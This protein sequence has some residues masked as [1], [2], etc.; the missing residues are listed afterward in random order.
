M[1]LWLLYWIFLKATLS[2]FSGMAALPI[3]R[4]ELVVQRQLLTDRDLNKAIVIGRTTPGPK[5]L[6]VV[7]LGQYLA[8]FPG[9]CLAALALVTPALLVIPLMQ[10]AARRVEHPGVQRSLRTIVLATAGVSLSAAI[11]LAINSLHDALGWA[12][13]LASGGLLI[14][15][16]IDPLLIMMVSAGINLC[17]WW[18]THNR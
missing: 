18:L 2:S 9:A 3:L 11:P 8:G 15:T 14:R 1:K 6:Y 13:A 5:G 12:L 10:F 7:A 17:Y 4:D 16:K